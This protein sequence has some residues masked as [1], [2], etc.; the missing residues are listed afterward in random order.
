[1]F[2]LRHWQQYAYRDLMGSQHT[3]GQFGDSHIIAISDLEVIVLCSYH[4]NESIGVL[5]TVT[6]PCAYNE[7]HPVEIE[8][9]IEIMES[10]LILIN[11][12]GGDNRYSKTQW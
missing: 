9:I 7:R 10:S 4:K 1:M 12:V 6:I 8:T 11:E 3:I 5:K 2:L